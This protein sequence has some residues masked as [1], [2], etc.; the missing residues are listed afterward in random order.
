[1]SDERKL[2][3]EDREK[4]GRL[5]ASGTPEN[6]NLA[7]S[8]VEQTAD[9]EDIAD[10]FTI[11]VIVELVCINEPENLERLMR[12][13]Q[14]IRRC[15]AT[16]KRFS[17]AV[18]D[19]TFLTSQRC[20]GLYSII[21]FVNDRYPSKYLEID[22]VQLSN[23]TA[24]STGAADQL[25]ENSG[26]NGRLKLGGLTFLSDAVAK[27]LSQFSGE[28][29]L[30]GLT[31][32]SDAT[33]ES[34]GRHQGKLSLM[35]LERLSVAA[36]EGLSKHSGILQ[37]NRK[38]RT[39]IKKT[40]TNEIAGRF[41]AV[42]LSVNLSEFTAIMDEAAE[43]LSKSNGTWLRLNGLTSLSDESAESLG[44]HKGKLSLRGL[45]RLSEEA[46]ASLAK[47]PG[48][49]KTNTK[50][51]GLLKKHASSERKKTIKSAATGQRVL[52]KQQVTQIRKL[53]RDKSAGQ[54]QIALQMLE[55]AGATVDDVSDV[56]S[57]SIVSLIANTWD[58]D[59]WNS[60]A[61]LFSENHLP[62][63]EFID[64]VRQ[65][66]LVK[67]GPFR[68]SFFLSL[69][70][71]ASLTLA[72]LITESKILVDW[73]VDRW[74]SH[75][76]TELSM[77]GAELLVVYGTVPMRD[78][79]N[80]YRLLWLDELT[81]LSDD[82]AQILGKHK[83]LL[84]LDGLTHLLDAAEGLSK[85][86]GSLS[87]FGLKS[88]SDESAESLGHHKG[89]LFLGGLTRLSATAA[90]SLRKNEGDLILS[91]PSYPKNVGLPKLSDAAAESLRKHKHGLE[92]D[93][94]TELSD[95][96]VES[97]SNHGG[98]Y[99]SLNSLT[100]LSDGAAE[101]FSR[102]DG[103][104]RLFGLTVLSD[105]AAQHLSIHPSLATHLGNLPASA[106]QI[107]RDA[108]EAD[109]ADDPNV[110]SEALGSG[111]T[112]DDKILTLEVA[113][114]FVAGTV[115]F[116]GTYITIED[117]AAQFLANCGKNKLI[118]NY[119]QSLTD[120][121]AEALS[122]YPGD[123]RLLGLKDISDTAV[124]HLAKHSNLTIKLDNL[125]ASAAQILRD[126]GHGE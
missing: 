117:D 106:A 44:Q 61:P 69:F 125:P 118:I 30:D 109:E 96:A 116:F 97:L 46:I 105:A 10:I 122:E 33:A 98:G 14:V 15:S 121:S 18:V 50:T 41:L 123:L 25:V 86:E 70:A 51:R 16:W 108:R 81:Q 22:D 89:G 75:E 74:K 115:L 38:I 58:I 114:A 26:Y 12:A 5:L 29:R 35:G 120:A 20:Q 104:L 7:L 2:T 63:Q 68:K 53:L 126:A 47:Y 88:I 48:V 100:E 87:F 62:R 64:L 91:S 21:E 19:P 103:N 92:L 78:R 72:P 77:G 80:D 79:T 11:N 56:F 113:E 27:S 83:G 112:L 90:E 37:T 71:R 54:T 45:K 36:A 39:H 110:I 84:R 67:S 9:Q 17:E 52:A 82:V 102:H 85:V 23:F 31:D 124:E 32:I 43:S 99:L 76:V 66:I 24:I 101:S 94:L 49:L 93:A 8:L 6:I 55:S 57:T 3:D 59:I 34:L 40:L 65:R 4:I 28:L 42:Q 60:L 95:A 73:E 13:G 111:V 107:L 1:M 119:I